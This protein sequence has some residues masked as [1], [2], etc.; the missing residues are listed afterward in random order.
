MVDPAVAYVPNEDYTPYDRGEAQGV[1]INM[2]NG[3]S[4]KGVVW[5]GVTVYPGTSI[6]R[7]VYARVC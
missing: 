5:P 2:P 1:W 3:T 4:M 7:H 6:L